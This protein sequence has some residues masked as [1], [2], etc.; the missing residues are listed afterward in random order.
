VLQYALSS[1]QKIGRLDRNWGQSGQNCRCT[2]DIAV[3]L[4]SNDDQFAF[5][6]RSILRVK[7]TLGVVWRHG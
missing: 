1:S 5:V 6:G 4:Q 7:M 3:L 2:V